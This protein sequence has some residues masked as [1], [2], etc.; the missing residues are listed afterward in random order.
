MRQLRALAAAGG[1]AGVDDGRD[2][3]AGARDGV[4]LV[5]HE[6]GAFEQAAAAVVAQREH[7]AGPARERQ[8]ADP[9]EVARRADHQR[10]RGVV[11]EIVDLARLV[12]RVQRHVDQAGAQHAE[13]EHHSLDRLVHVHQHA[14]AGGQREV[15]EQVGD[16]GA[17]ALEILPRVVQRHECG[18]RLVA[19]GG[20][21]GLDRDGVGTRR[22]ERAQS[23]VQI[24]VVGHVSSFSCGSGADRRDC[25]AQNFAGRFSM[26]AARP[27]RCSSVSAYA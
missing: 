27:S 26:N 15:G 20:V 12:G 1:A 11:D 3:V 2:V 8:A 14:C 22:E 16:A 24:G 9:G 19:A 18:V 10:R 4:E 5:A 25:A 17:A 6:R 7:H 21:G 23:G 13:V